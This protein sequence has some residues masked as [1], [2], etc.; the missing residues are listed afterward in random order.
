MPF[1]SLLLLAMVLPAAPD[2]TAQLA[3]SV[4]SADSA[5]FVNAAAPPQDFKLTPGPPATHTAKAPSDDVCYK[6]RAYI[7]KRDDDH[8]P[9]YVGTT[10]CGPGSPHAKSVVEPKVKLVPAN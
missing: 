7:F 5:F 4:N 9:E 10:T 2:R 3:P 1:A 6:I 8:A